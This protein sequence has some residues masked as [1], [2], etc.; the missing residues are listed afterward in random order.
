MADLIATEGYAQSIG[1]VPISYTSNLGCTKSRAIA[2]GCNVAGTYTDKQLVC[3]K[4]LSKTSTIK[5]LLRNLTDTYLSNIRVQA[6]NCLFTGNISAGGVLYSTSAPSGSSWTTSNIEL[7]TVNPSPDSDTYSYVIQNPTT[8]LYAV[9]RYNPD[10]IA[11]NNTG[12]YMLSSPN[13][14]LLGTKNYVQYL[15]IPSNFIIYVNTANSTGYIGRFRGNY[16]A[17]QKGPKL[18]TNGN[19]YIVLYT[20]ID[21]SSNTDKYPAGTIIEPWRRVHTFRYYSNTYYYSLDI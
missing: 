14:T 5:Y 16:Y 15:D 21:T 2:L 13:T 8:Y 18:M 1:N 3:Q 6:G 19:Q 20:I 11:G 7:Y 4:D 9:S 10:S 17:D 12:V